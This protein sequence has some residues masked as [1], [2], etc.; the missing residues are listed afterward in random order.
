LHRFCFP[1]PKKKKKTAPRPR[2]GEKKKSISSR[3]GKR[4]KKKRWF[5]SFKGGG[6]QCRP[7]GWERKREERRDGHS[8]PHTTEGKKKKKLRVGGRKVAFVFGGGEM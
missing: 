2:K 4:R 1:F 7:S 8:D 5:L 6:N 3:K